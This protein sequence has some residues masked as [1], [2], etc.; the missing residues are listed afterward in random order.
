MQ[1]W[2]IE[3][4]IC[5]I[6]VACASIFSLSWLGCAYFTIVAIVYY[7]RKNGFQGHQIVITIAG[8]ILCFPIYIS[9]MT[10]SMAHI[11]VSLDR[12]YYN[13]SDKVLITTQ[14]KGYACNYEICGIQKDGVYQN[15][16]FEKKKNMLLLDAYTIKNNYVSVAVIGPIRSF[17]DFFVYPCNK[18][19][20]VKPSLGMID[21]AMVRYK[22]VDVNVKP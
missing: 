1:S 21:P 11:E 7:L 8:L 5:V 2:F 9:L 15:T 4:L 20:D 13:L 6:A 19:M 10:M 17:K 18:I 3:T 22:R 16:R 12:D 14:V